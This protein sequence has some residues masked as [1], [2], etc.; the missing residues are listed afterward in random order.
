MGK[1]LVITLLVLV[2][3]GLFVGG[4]GPLTSAP[5]TN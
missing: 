3:L 4:V 5:T 2:G 1:G